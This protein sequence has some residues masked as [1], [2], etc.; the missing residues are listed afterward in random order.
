MDKQ[1]RYK[2]E[3]QKWEKVIS[4]LENLNIDINKQK[5]LN[6]A[7]HNWHCS[8]EP[9]CLSRNCNFNFDQFCKRRFLDLSVDGDCLNRDVTY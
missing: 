1:E 6:T 2:N 5:K 8:S 7:L 9:H 4:E 3:R